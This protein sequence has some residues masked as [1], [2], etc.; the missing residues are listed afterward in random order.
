MPTCLCMLLHIKLVSALQ[1]S[2]TQTGSG[3]ILRI[4][5]RVPLLPGPSSPAFTQE[6]SAAAWSWRNSTVSAAITLLATHWPFSKSTVCTCTLWAVIKQKVAWY[7]S[8]WVSYRKMRCCVWAIHLRAVPCFVWSRSN[9]RPHALLKW[10]QLYLGQ[11]G[12]EQYA[13]H[14]SA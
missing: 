4:F 12:W 13:L 3:A 8:H 5:F 14:L 9:S 7:R 11:L 10:K 2:L 6:M 1:T